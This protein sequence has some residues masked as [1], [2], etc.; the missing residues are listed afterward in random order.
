[1][2]SLVLAAISTLVEAALLQ[3]PAP[4]T[5]R[6][7]DPIVVRFDPRLNDVTCRVTLTGWS[8]NLAAPAGLLLPPCELGLSLIADGPSS[9]IDLRSL[10]ARVWLDSTELPEAGARGRLIAG[11]GEGSRVAVVSLPEFTGQSIRWETSFR[12]ETFNIRVDEARA[13]QITWP[14]HWPPEL[15]RFLEAEPFIESADPRFREFVERVSQGRLREV[16]PFV[17]AKEL[18]RAAALFPTSTV[19]SGVVRQGLGAINGIDVNGAV[20]LLASG[21]GTPADGVCLA[22]AVLRAAGIPA[23]PVLGVTRYDDQSRRFQSRGGVGP[24]VWG[25]FW[26]PQAG[27]IPFDPVVMR[28]QA[29]PQAGIQT[30]WKGFASFRDLN[31]LV[32]LAWSFVPPAPLQPA[33]PPAMWGSSLAGLVTPAIG[34]PVEQRVAYATW[35]LTNR[36]AGPGVP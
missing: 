13:A 10:A 7:P 27:W 28:R 23:R 17:A 26:L 12:A 2:T 34:G 20:S 24:W 31:A 6:L 9:L 25:E 11:G 18:V 1:M 15:H 19:G 14:R 16:P 32:P 22:V 3:R 4:P 21:V 33:G 30:A 5:P 35:I 29:L 36:G 8:G